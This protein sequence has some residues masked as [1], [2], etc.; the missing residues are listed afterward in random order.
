MRGVVVRALA[1]SVALWMGGIAHAA[2]D[3]TESKSLDTGRFYVWLQTGHTAIFK[4]KVASDLEFDTPNGINVMLGGGGGYNLTDHWSIEF[5]GHGTEPD[6]RSKSLGKVR[7]YSNITL[8]PG[9]R[10]RWPFDDGHFVPWISAGIGASMNDVNDTGNTRIKLEADDMTIAGSIAAGFDYF[11]SPNVAI[12]ISLQSLI[13]PSQDA[14]VTLRDNANRIILDRKESMNLTSISPLAHIRVFPGQAGDGTSGRRYL[15]ADHGPFDTDDIRGYIYVTGGHTQLFDKGYGGGLKLEAPGDF[16]ATLGG[17]VG[18][19]IDRYLGVE[20]QLTNTDP[21]IIGRPY[22]K[23]IELSTFTVMPLVKLRYP[24]LDGRLVPYVRGGVG[25][26]FY[27]L[28]DGRPAVDVINS[29]GTGATTVKT[30]RST[31]QEQTY[32]GQIGVGVEYFLN[33]HVSVGLALPFNF[34]P[35]LKT[36]VTVGNRPLQRGHVNFTGLAGMIELKAYFN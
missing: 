25:V 1:L 11:L 34:Y 20:V 16:N 19:N 31:V 5:Q 13:Y 28:N 2:N 30:P 8:L 14:R 32:A 27:D 24:F 10:F 35:D 21:N 17:G 36:R 18:L 7:E 6:V 3:T 33:H 26:A 12:G 29:T 9:V 22:G 23:V 15:L 4:K